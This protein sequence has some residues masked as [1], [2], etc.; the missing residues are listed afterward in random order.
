MKWLALSLGVAFAC[1]IAVGQQANQV[2][3][4]KY[5]LWRPPTRLRGANTWQRL[6]HHRLSPAY[7]CEGDI[8]S[9][10]RLGAN[11]LNISHPGILSE[12]R[13]HG[14]YRLEEEALANLLKLV[15]C[16]GQEGMFVVVAYRTGPERKE[17]IF[18]EDHHAPSKVFEDERAKTAW[19][20]MWTKTV[21]E[22]KDLPYV[23]GYDLMVEPDTGG[24]P[25]RWR[26]LAKS[27]IKK[28]REHDQKTPILLE[29]ADGGDLEALLNSSVKEFDANTDQR[30][31][32]CVH[33]YQ[34]DK[35]SQQ[36]EGKWH[37]KC[38][39]LKNK[40]GTPDPSHYVPYSAQ[41]NEMLKEVYAAVVRWRNEQKVPVAINEFGVV[42]WAGAWSGNKRTGHPVPDADRFISDQLE[43]LESIGVSHAIWKWDPATCEGDDDYN[44]MHGQIF[45]SHRD[46]P[47]KLGQNIISNWQK[48]NLRPAFG[49]QGVVGIPK[50]QDF[51]SSQ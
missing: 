24:H 25:E 22:L 11:Y 51:N 42:R 3:F 27:I 32:F 34:P 35:Y 43:L 15:K 49:K 48:N 46:A 31:V 1:S 13:D 14:Q 7:T 47:S 40:K 2:R 12:E 20:E 9:L 4:D 41:M 45:S 33:Q 29:G 30:L 38:P 44:F 10:A 8:R 6:E 36:T 28:I 5:D 19:V 50:R 16:A 26:E 21:E 18:E 23:V 39:S 37:Y 17:E